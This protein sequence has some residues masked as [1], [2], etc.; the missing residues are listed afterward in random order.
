MCSSSIVSDDKDA[1]MHTAHD[2]FVRWHRRASFLAYTYYKYVCRAHLERKAFLSTAL[3]CALSVLVVC[4]SLCMFYLCICA[5]FVCTTWCKSVTRSFYWFQHNAYACKTNTLN[6][7]NMLY[8][9]SLALC[10]LLS[11]SLSLFLSHF[12]LLHLCP[13]MRRILLSCSLCLLVFHFLD[14]RKYKPHT[15]MYTK[16]AMPSKTKRAQSLFLCA[17]V[18]A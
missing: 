5:A 4:G 9:F 15:S 7:C 6:I 2:K 11:L 3:H 1:F 18:F 8:S 10:I 13:C 12:V 16:H 14:Q 17:G